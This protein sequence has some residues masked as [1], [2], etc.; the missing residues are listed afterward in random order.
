MASH[1]GAAWRILAAVTLI[2]EIA[3]GIVLAVLILKFWRE[4]LGIALLLGV[5][6]VLLVVGGLVLWV[7]VEGFLYHERWAVDLLI[8]GAVAGSA[9]AANW[10]LNSREKSRQDRR[11]EL[12]YDKQ[13]TE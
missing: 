4:T 11:K 5:L 9:W 8:L 1:D 2:L 13:R 12:G 3:A 6:S 10:Y 7:G